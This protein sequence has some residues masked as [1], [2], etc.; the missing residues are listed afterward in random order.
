M[1]VPWYSTYEY[2]MYIRHSPYG[3]SSF[4]QVFLSLYFT[5]HI[6]SRLTIFIALYSTAEP[7]VLPDGEVHVPPIS[8]FPAAVLGLFIFVFHFLLIAWYKHRRVPGFCDA[9]PVQRFVHVLVNT[10]VAVPF[11]TWDVDMPSSE[12]E[13][14]FCESTNKGEGS[15]Q[16]R[17]KRSTSCPATLPA[18]E[19]AAAAAAAA[20]AARPN[21]AP[22][23]KNGDLKRPLVSAH[24]HHR[25]EANLRPGQPSVTWP[26]ISP[27]LRDGVMSLR[28]KME[29]LWWED[30]SRPITAAMVR[31]GC[32]ETVALLDEA[33]VAEILSDVDRNGFVNKRGLYLPRK[34]KREY[35]W[36]FAFHLAFN[37]IA[38]VIEVRRLLSPTGLKS[39]RGEQ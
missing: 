18:D 15:E 33:A 26:N 23:D 29:E 2:G 19:V 10:L 27:E 17:A 24:H 13:D 38:L 6:V 12:D 31:R 8:L 9:D 16:P 21:P 37:L 20:A 22:G 30:P 1:H 39:R 32:G 25:S 3:S 14:P 35:F 34:T 4:L 7:S 28:G 11:S 36:L 5:C